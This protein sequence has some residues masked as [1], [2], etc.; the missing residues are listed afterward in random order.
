MK[1]F[2]MCGGLILLAALGLTARAEVIR[3]TAFG[4]GADTYL[5]NDSQQGPNTNTGTEVRMRAW[6]QLA[7]TRCKIGY[8]RFDIEGVAGDFS[9]STLTLHYTYMK[10]SQS[11]ITVY[12]VKD[13]PDDFWIESGTGGITYNTA[14]GLLATTLGNYSIDTNKAVQLGTFI[15]PGV[16][17]L[18]FSVTTNPSTLNLSSFLASDTNGLVTFFFIGPDDE[19]EIATKERTDGTPPPSLN[20]PNA[21]LGKAINP[22]PDHDSYVNRF[23]L[24]QLQWELL[25]GVGKCDVYFGT[26]PNTATMSKLTFAP[27]V[28][29]VNIN[30]FA[31]YSVPLAE[32]S[33]YWRVDCYDTHPTDPNKFVG[34]FWKF[35]ATAAP[36]FV[37]ISPAYQAKFV[38][39]TADV[40]TASFSSGSSMTYTWYRSADNATNT[41]ADDVVVG[42]NSNT[43]ALGTLAKSHAG[44][45]YCVASG[46]GGQTASSTVRVSIKQ[47]IAYY[48]FDGNANDSSG[49]NLHGTL[50]GEPTFAAGIFGQALLFDGIDDYVQL[51][52]GFDDFSPGITISVWAR[53]AAVTNWARFVDLGN[54]AAS[55]NIYLSRNSTSTN[56]TYSHYRA[57]ISAGAVTAA[58]A[59]NL[60]EWQMY[61]AVMDSSGNVTLYRNGI[62]VQTGAIPQM[63]NIL[64][65][66]NNYIGESNWADDA[67]YSGLMDDVQIWNY[68]LTADQIA[69]MYAAGAGSF[70]RFRPQLDYSG[71][72]RVDL[73]DLA[74]F[75]QS[76]LQCGIHPDC[77]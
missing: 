2:K 10:G 49:N 67:F 33:Y 69:D 73:A 19:D 21:S 26:D 74:V 6:R 52:A 57:A 38:G 75:A 8:I 71:N 59:L 64:V 30:S 77:Q 41:A 54:G 29:S 14:P 66:N 4:R 31:G 17:T 50:M 5:T 45:Y 20:M 53:P 51:P 16:Q 37:S 39:E 11:T 65:R 76:W 24:T 60:N 61:A 47:Q 28:T 63:P 46:T 15:S 22:N 35:T 18:P 27:A 70:C 58:G 43:L 40:I 3:T 1:R 36:I 68:P 62:P 56:L 12:G 72:C 55:D 42:T 7:N 48:T 13:G 9:N 34:P 44:W 32:R 23:S 25:P